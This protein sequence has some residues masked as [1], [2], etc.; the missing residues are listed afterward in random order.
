MATPGTQA[1]LSIGQQLLNAKKALSTVP[2]GSFI[3]NWIIARKI[4]YSATTGARVVILEPGFSKLVL[5]DKKSIRNHLNSI[6][7]VAL[8]NFG[9]LTS[10]LALNTCLP[11][12]VRGIVTHINSNYLKKARGTLTAECRCE[13]P[14]V[15]SDVDYTVEAIIK[16]H[17]REIVARVSVVWRLGLIKSPL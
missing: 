5:K 14:K 15:S 1:S 6:H 10:G 8:T 13:P 12:N 9:E 4:P 2:G 7:A 17:A 3:F 16:D 11:Q